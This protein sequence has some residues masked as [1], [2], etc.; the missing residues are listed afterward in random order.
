M[1]VTKFGGRRV[2]VLAVAAV[3]SLVLAAC[4]SSSSGGGSSSASGS[5][6]GSSSAADGA[7]PAVAALVPDQYKSTPINNG[8][9]NDYPPQEFLQGDQLTG[10]QY[11]LVTEMAKVAGV[12]VNFISVGGFDTLIPGIT[13]GRYDMSSGDFGVTADRVKQV[14]FVTQ[15]AIGTGFAV[16]TGSAIKVNQATDL[17]GHSVGVQAGSYFIDQLKEANAECTKAGLKPIDTQ[18]F[19]NDTSRTQAAVNGRIEITATSADA[20]GYAIS[21]QNV[22]LVMQPFVY[23]PTE[24]GI[25]F[26]KG[27]KLGAAMQAAL[28]ELVKNGTYL[29]VLKKWGVESVAYSTPDQVKYITDVSQIPAS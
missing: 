8:F 26:P 24:H 22:P 13:S 6:S 18:T 14:D 11:D 5:A 4:G 2:A 7:V 17:C 21:S 19:P 27:S 3:G 12:K 28:Q 23:A 15:F 1:N 20:L 25:I 29:T 9:Y 16:K 10:I